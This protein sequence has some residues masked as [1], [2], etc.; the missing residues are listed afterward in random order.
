MA[1]SREYPDLAFVQPRAWGAGRDGRSVQYAVIHYTAG[2]ERATSA[3]DGAAYDAR[4]TDGTSTHYFHDQNSTVQC[5]YTQDRANAAL[6]KG[7]RL[8][9]QH[10][11]CG[12]VQSRDQWL[13]AASDATLWRAAK[14]V[15]RDCRRYGL[16]VRRLSVAETRAAWYA[17]AGARP[18]GIVGHIDVTYAY[19]EDGGDHT[20]PGPSFPWDV[21]LERVAGYVAHGDG[22]T[23]QL[24]PEVLETMGNQ[25]LVRFSDAADPAQVWLC[26][27]M[28]RRRVPAATIPA[29]GNGQTHAAGYLGELG[30]GGAVFVSA[31]DQDIW[32]IDVASLGGGSGGGVPLTYAETKAACREAVEDS[33]DS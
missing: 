6:H 10:E 30:N 28:L 33:E 17:P 24:T 4:R 8:G 18:K 7:N 21:L 26:D 23:G 22:W 11:I 12:T 1:Q 5:V 19:P 14:Q 13:D 9:I 27:G 20:D 2:S 29:V 32:G 16:P 25:M 15:A 3:E 31:G